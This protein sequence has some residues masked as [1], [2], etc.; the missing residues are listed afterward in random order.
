M[1]SERRVDRAF[2]VASCPLDQGRYSHLGA[3]R[4]GWSRVGEPVG[5]SRHDDSKWPPVLQAHERRGQHSD[6]RGALRWRRRAASAVAVET[7]REIGK[8]IE[9]FGAGTML[10]RPGTPREI[11][12]GILFLASDDASFITSTL[13]FI[14]GGKTAM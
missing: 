4:Q 7:G 3:A 2:P 1:L 10:K 12:H 14:D 13:L 9:E 5:A 11:A 8:F 6:R